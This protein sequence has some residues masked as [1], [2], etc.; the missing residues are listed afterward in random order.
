MHL[1][2]AIMSILP[3]H[4][5]SKFTDTNEIFSLI[6]HPSEQILISADVTGAIHFNLFDL[7]N[8]EVSLPE[9]MGSRPYRPHKESCRS[10]DVMPSKSDGGYDI[11][12]G[13]SDGRLVVSNFNPA[14]I[15]KWKVSEQGVNVVKAV[16]ENLLVAG[17]DDGAIHVVDLRERK[18]IFS[19]H[20]QSDYISALTCG[21]SDSPLKSL[22]ALSGD[23]T[24]GVYDL[25]MISSASSGKK[26][27]RLVALSDEQ[28][29][30]LNCIAV[31]NA[32]Q[33]IITGDGHGVVGIWKQGFWGDLK[34]RIPLYTKGENSGADGSHSI[35]GLKKVTE[36]SFLTVT[37][38]GIIRLMNL[39]P[40]DVERIIGVHRSEDETEI[41]TISG[42]DCDVELGLIAT[43]AGDSSGT[44]KFWSLDQSNE[45]QGSDSEQDMHIIEKKKLKKK[46]NK[47]SHKSNVHSNPDRANKQSFF[48]DL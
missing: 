14:S 46:V 12:S 8:K 20:E 16:D 24:L 13:G 6:F 1:F 22:I 33:N 3:D 38:D 17:D 28:E 19:I 2:L 11:I 40:N 42:F 32:E 41:A 23:C 48:S 25:R 34:D 10:I 43:A 21:L 36:K 4:C 37:S 29:D 45:E 15:G 5:I 39:F 31:V 35:D 9:G 7:D 26:K 47:R 18:K 27:D 30:E 44:I